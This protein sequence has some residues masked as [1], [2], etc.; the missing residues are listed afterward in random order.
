MNIPKGSLTI[1]D[2]SLSARNQL[3]RI[4]SGTNTRVQALKDMHTLYPNL[5]KLAAHTFKY[6][7]TEPVK[8]TPVDP[9]RL[10]R[11]WK[12]DLLRVY[13]LTQQSEQGMCLALR[14]LRNHNRLRTLVY[15]STDLMKRLGHPDY[16][17]LHCLFNL[18]DGSADIDLAVCK[19]ENF[20][21]RTASSDVDAGV[22][23]DTDKIFLDKI[24]P[25]FHENFPMN[26][27]DLGS[28]H[29]EFMLRQAEV[30][31][32]R[33]IRVTIGNP[34]S[35]GKALVEEYTLYPDEPNVR[36]LR[37]L[38]RPELT[39]AAFG[40]VVD[41]SDRVV[42]P[43]MVALLALQL[44]DEVNFLVK[45]DPEE[46]SIAIIPGDPHGGADTLAEILPQ[47][48]NGLLSSPQS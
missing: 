39:N 26:D 21:I 4:F 47:G 5:G 35:N 28:Y 36:L 43:W 11:V 13:F 10:S 33:T 25:V 19:E 37:K 44:P 18:T 1:H 24:D 27:T 45:Y 12:L 3:F 7:F 48:S 41:V 22:F 16:I 46:K 29:R 2:R 42:V 40:G 38:R 34:A 20:A 17:R 9:E 8:D 23:F 14:E 32:P 6:C 30:K 15:D 31:E